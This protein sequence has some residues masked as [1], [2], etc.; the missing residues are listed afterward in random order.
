[1][2]A[3]LRSKPLVEL[4]PLDHLNYLRFVN[5]AVHPNQ[6][7]HVAPNVFTLA[8][9]AFEK[10]WQCRG[11]LADG[12]PAGLAVVRVMEASDQQGPAA[13]LPITGEP[14]LLRFMVD[15]RW[16]GRGVG[17]RALLEILQWCRQFP[18]A[19][20]LFV[21]HELGPAHPGPF[22]AACGF[23]PTGEMLNGEVLLE[24]RLP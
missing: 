22:Y 18:T 19:T 2:C 14:F 24:H 23:L 9:A 1:M 6:E 7:A 21:T 5:L 20:R 12:T 16:Q 13:H 8:Q 3:V 17:R 4:V 11:V 10:G 15:A